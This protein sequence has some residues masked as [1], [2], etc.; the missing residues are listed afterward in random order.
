MNVANLPQVMVTMAQNRS[1]PEVLRSVVGGIAQCR[2][3]VL[4]R[5]W[6][7]EPGDI[8]ATCRFRPECP[9]QSRC[10]HLVASAG[11]P[12]DPQRDYTRLDGAFRRF[13]LG[14]RKTGHVGKTGEPLLLPGLRGDENWIAE[15]EWIKRSGIHTV[16]AQD[17]KSVVEG[18]GVETGGEGVSKR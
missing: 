7:I 12:D 10:L 13:P 8:C 1:L 6:L 2:N 3:V 11:N 9:D 16:A 5:I 15:P 18:K 17:R 4:A 14:V